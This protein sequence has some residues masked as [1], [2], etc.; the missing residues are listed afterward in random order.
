M[1]S[2]LE[3]TSRWLD[4]LSPEFSVEMTRLELRQAGDLASAW[5][6][7]RRRLPKAGEKSE[8][9]EGV[10]QFVLRRIGT[11][12]RIAYGTTD[13]PLAPGPGRH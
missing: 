1:D 5:V 11:E 4:R 7:V 9:Q 12:W 3:R 13:L 8:E 2:A 6:S 10:E